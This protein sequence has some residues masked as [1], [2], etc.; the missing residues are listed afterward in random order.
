[1]QEEIL[2]RIQN[3]NQDEMSFLKLVLD[4]L[5]YERVKDKFR[6]YLE[7]LNSQ[8]E[9]ESSQKILEYANTT[10]A[11]I[12]K[13][14]INSDLRTDQFG[15]LSKACVRS[16]LCTKLKLDIHSTYSIVNSMI[17]SGYLVQG[18]K[19]NEISIPFYKEQ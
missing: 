2:K 14:I 8:V 3:L 16:F 6:K 4:F 13:E 9:I 12:V 17:K 1:M 7:I 5:D 15:W 18:N 11:S 19:P 10:Y